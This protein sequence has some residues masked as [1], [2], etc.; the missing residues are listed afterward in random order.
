MSVRKFL[1]SVADVFA[2]DNTSQLV[3]TGKTLLD[4]SI[5]VSLG[6]AP[7]R[8]GR[9]NQLQYIYYHTGEMKFTL[10]DTQWNL[11]MLSATVGDDVL[12]GNNVFVEENVEATVAGNNVTA[13]I[14]GTA[15]EWAG[16][17]IIYGWA[18]LPSGTILNGT[19]SS[20]TF[21]A[22]KAATEELSTGDHICVRYYAE[23]SSSTSITVSA[24][25]IPKV[26]R[27]VMET[28]LNSADVTTNKIGV[29][30]IIAPT[31]T[32]SGAF[33]LSMKSDGVANTPLTATALAYSG[34]STEV[35]CTTSPYY[36]KIV[37]ILDDSDWY[38]N[39][40]ALAIEGGDFSIPNGEDTT[41]TVWAVPA[42][43][44]A[45]K[46]PVGD[47][48]FASSSEA[49]ATIGEHTGLVETVAGGS[50]TL[51]VFIT[52]LSSVEASCTCTVTT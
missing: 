3:F 38:T 23:N 26:V 44:S 31:V 34:D 22:T 51:S 28:Q 32:L 11:G 43:G 14:A 5:E 6:S 7:V 16:D 39:V 52:E 24:N 49:A 50:T 36:A 13:T 30:Q 48:T 40:I 41:L 1:T 2:Y 20:Q 42:Q 27:L 4:S 45:F 46:P 21:S 47:L 18:T 35:A 12:T 19:F 10:T 37:E 9:G 17:T 25:M 33:T 8:G 29:V 15:L